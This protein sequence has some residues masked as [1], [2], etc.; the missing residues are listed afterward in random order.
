MNDLKLDKLIKNIC[1]GCDF[2]ATIDKKDFSLSIIHAKDDIYS[3]IDAYGNNSEGYLAMSKSIID[4]NDFARFK[5]I[6]V[7]EAL[8]NMRNGDRIERV[9]KLKNGSYK[10]VIISSFVD[11][12]YLTVKFIDTT[13]S[14]KDLALK[15]TI[16]SD[17]I[18][19]TYTLAVVI[20][21]ERDTIAKIAVENEEVILKDYDTAWS[22][23]Y[24][25]TLKRVHPDDLPNYI[26]KTH[27][28]FF[29]SCPIGTNVKLSYRIINKG[30]SDYRYLNTQFFVH[31]NGIH[32]RTMVALMIDNT[33][34]IMEKNE[35]I[36]ISER[37][38]LT[39]LYNRSKLDNMIESE[40]VN[41]RC[42]G[43]LFFDINNLKEIND[44][45]GHNEGDEC[46][47]RA[48]EAIRSITNRSIHAYRY[49]GDEFIVVAVNVNQSDLDHLVL[50]VRQ[51][52]ADLNKDKT[53]E[54][55]M[56]IG[57]S[58]ADNDID[59]KYLITLA[60]IDMYKEKKEMKRAL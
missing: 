60:D 40:Y 23:V 46:I 47:I 31:E 37:D 17:S 1:V 36:K 41:L 15:N 56:A 54:C 2:V 59:I 4:E 34:T 43:I 38:N 58:F 50:L 55:R 3:A 32:E 45:L 7:P 44:T 29:R 39:Y 13:S 51:R 18:N 10:K 33:K 22:K 52:L 57:K 35:L 30:Y 5:E 49:G 42:C 11:E 27:P 25:E 24:E 20:N 8:E 48:A 16:L 26:S 6:V 14:K 12:D 21:L 28:A 9:I 19:G 53:F